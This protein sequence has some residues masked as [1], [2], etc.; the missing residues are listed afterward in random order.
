MSSKGSKGT[1]TPPSSLTSSPSFGKGKKSPNVNR[2]SVKL[3]V[4]KSFTIDVNQIAVARKQLK[5][6]G[7]GNKNNTEE[8]LS[9]ITISA[10]EKQ[11]TL[12]MLDTSSASSWATSWCVLKEGRLY[13]FPNSKAPSPDKIL[14]LQGS[15]VVGEKKLTMPNQNATFDNCFQIITQQETLVFRSD[16]D[17]E[18]I[19]W[20][21]QLRGATLYLKIS[22]IVKETPGRQDSSQTTPPITPPSSI[23]PPTPSVTSPPSPASTRRHDPSSSSP[24]SS[25]ATFPSTPPLSPLSLTHHHISTPTTPATTSPTSANSPSTPNFSPGLVRRGTPTQNQKSPNFATPTSDVK[26]TFRNSTATMT[27]LTPLSPSTSDSR[28]TPNYRK[29]TDVTKLSRSMDLSPLQDVISAAYRKSADLSKLNSS[30]SSP[31]LSHSSSPHL[32]HSSPHLSHSSPHLSSSSGSLFASAEILPSESKDDQEGVK[33]KRGFLGVPGGLFTKWKQRWVVLSND[34]LSVYK[35]P[36]D[37]ERQD[38]EPVHSF[39][40]IFCQPKVVQSEKGKFVFEIHAPGRTVQF[41]ASS[42]VELLEWITCIQ[43]SQTSLMQS[44]LQYNLNSDSKSKS[45]DGEGE[46]GNNKQQQ[47]SHELEKSKKKLQDI[48][49][50]IP[51]NNQCADCG[52]SEPQG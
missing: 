10:P 33:T 26:T 5:N 46:D 19:T 20:I 43:E 27:P 39:E 24:L 31:H 51:G 12:H 32:P 13:I 29:S 3:D 48:I 16:E 47:L 30:V 42:S 8:A 44:Y 15:K 28:F 34:F 14:S 40:L 1:H 11:G 41:G 35:H 36:E 50:Q 37:E 6:V 4:P 22:E 17:F 2:K 21:V 25:P 9:S 38:K 23:T 45:D 52:A 18:Y 49:S 7:K